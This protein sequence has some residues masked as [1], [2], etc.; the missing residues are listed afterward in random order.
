MDVGPALAL[1][2]TTLRPSVLP[3]LLPSVVPTVRPS[4][5]PTA[6]PTVS[7]TL[8][9]LSVVEQVTMDLLV[10]SSSLSEE[11]KI[12]L[13]SSLSPTATPTDAP[14]FS[15]TKVPTTATPLPTWMPTLAP[16]Q[17]SEV[18]TLSPSLAPTLATCPGDC[19]SHG[20]C[21]TLD[22]VCDCDGGWL[23]DDCST[24][25]LTGH[26]LGNTSEL[27]SM[28]NPAQLTIERFTDPAEPLPSDL[29]CEIRTSDPTEAA[30]EIAS[31]EM[32]GA[33]KVLRIF[34]V[35]DFDED[36]DQPFDVLL[37]P[38]ESDK[39]PAYSFVGTV[40][41]ASTFNRHYK[42]PEIGAV[43]PPSIDMSGGNVV[44]AGEGMED[45]EEVVIDGIVISGPP[46][47]RLRADIEGADLHCEC[48]LANDFGKSWLQSVAPPGVYIDVCI[49]MCIYICMDIG[50]STRCV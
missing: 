36:G 33:T 26:V 37:G 49:H 48:E 7:P 32:Q 27:D 12:F 42:F 22:G 47:Y 10:E 44:M 17:A 11:T 20:V 13:E 31:F 29:R 30:M 45:V 50:R 39:S 46:I 19:S 16:T 18:N 41:I 9:P 34:G 15:P 38:C 6:H 8:T 23:R 40:T 25:A 43:S 4:M 28:Q 35:K 2:F 3:T 14:S 5:L 21:D 24:F 1:E